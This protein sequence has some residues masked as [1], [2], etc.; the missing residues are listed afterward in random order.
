MQ[1]DKNYDILIP[2]SSIIQDPDGLYWCSTRVNR[3]TRQHIGGKDYWGYCKAGCDIRPDVNATVIMNIMFQIG[4]NIF[5]TFFISLSTNF[6]VL[7][8]SWWRKMRTI[9]Q[10]SLKNQK[11]R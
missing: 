1:I 2:H 5:Y 11:Q 9:L 6:D 7:K 4:S 8:Y 3:K 10:Q